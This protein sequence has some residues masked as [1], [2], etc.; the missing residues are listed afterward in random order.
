LMVF[1]FVHVKTKQHKNGRFDDTSRTE[2]KQ[3]KTDAKAHASHH[4]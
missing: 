1:T 2:A 4:E 3:L